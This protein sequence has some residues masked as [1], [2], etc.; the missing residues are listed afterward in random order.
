MERKLLHCFFTF[1]LNEC[2][3]RWT[4]KCILLY[5][6]VITLYKFIFPSQE[7]K[8]QYKK[9]RHKFAHEKGFVIFWTAMFS[10]F[11]S[12]LKEIKRMKG[13][14]FCSICVYAELIMTLKKILLSFVSFLQWIIVLLLFLYI[15]DTVILKKIL[16]MF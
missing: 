10:S 9:Y 1:V 6:N 2:S 4:T 16:L 3:I 11:F 5:N 13:V 14:R 7:K 15:Q 8:L 12:F